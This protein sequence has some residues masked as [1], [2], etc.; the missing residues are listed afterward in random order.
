M[1]KKELFEFHAEFCKTFSNP[2]RLEILD[3]LKK[4]EA[5]VTDIAGKLDIQKS[6]VSQHLT[7]MRAMKILK[8]RRQGTKIYYKIA[9]PQIGQACSLMQDALARMLE[10]AHSV[11]ASEK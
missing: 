2:K 3:L 8:S 5:T 6:N 7:L 9:N 4:E 11:A 10:G 1:R